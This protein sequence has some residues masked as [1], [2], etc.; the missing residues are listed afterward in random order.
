MHMDPHTQAHSPHE[1]TRSQPRTSQTAMN[2]PTPRGTIT[3]PAPSLARAV[4]Q[5][6]WSQGSREA[7]SFPILS[8]SSLSLSVEGSSQPGRRQSQRLMGLRSPAGPLLSPPP[9]PGAAQAFPEWCGLLQALECDRALAHLTQVTEPPAD[10]ALTVGG[11]AAEAG[12]QGRVC[13]GELQP[14]VFSLQSPESQ[15]PTL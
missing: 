10:G 8:S 12:R 11:L 6:C 14:H 5:Q 13:R 9:G 3:R 15:T 4:Q 2:T 1:C 7:L